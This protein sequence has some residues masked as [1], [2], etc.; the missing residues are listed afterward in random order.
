MNTIQRM[1]IKDSPSGIQICQ[2]HQ[3]KSQSRNVLMK[4]YQRTSSSD[5]TVLS[6]IPSFSRPSSAALS[7]PHFSNMFSNII[8]LILPF[9][10]FPKL[11][12]KKTSYCTKFHKVFQYIKR[13]YFIPEEV[14]RTHILNGTKL[15]VELCFVDVPNRHDLSLKVGLKSLSQLFIVQIDAKVSESFFFKLF[16]F[17]G[18]R[19][20][21][22][23]N[24]L[25][26]LRLA[27]S[28]VL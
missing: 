4:I 2:Q 5:R 25:K 28:K 14:S 21:H 7:E 22:A 8:L 15:R 10:H 20:I 16:G 3:K 18:K 1:I 23:V 26:N 27:V 9:F 11:C 17:R 6:E 19:F 13:Y 12:Y 24:L